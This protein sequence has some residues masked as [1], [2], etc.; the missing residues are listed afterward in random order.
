MS[1][2]PLAALKRD[3]N[4]D[5]HGFLQGMRPEIRFLAAEDREAIF[6]GALEVL[7]G[8]GMQVLHPEGLELLR[9]G[10]CQVDEQSMVRIPASLVSQALTTAPASIPVYDRLGEPAMDLGA[11]RSYFGTG[12]DLIYALDGQS[13]ER[14]VAGLND[15]ARAARV[16]DA[17]PN[18]DFVMSFAHP[19]DVS[20]H[21]AYLAS[22][23]TMAGNTTKPI[24]NTAENRS[25]LTEI[26][27]IGSLLRGSN[28]ALRERPYTIHYAEPIS[29]LKHPFESVDKL[30]L[31]AQAGMPCIYSPAPMA[32][33]TAP[34]SIAGHVVQGLA[35][36][37]CGLVMH[38]LKQP[39]APF[40]MGMGAAVLDMVSSEC[41][42]NAPE[43]Y[44]SYMAMIEMSHHLDLPSWG[45]AGTSDSQIPDGQATYEAGM[46]S[47]L[48]A[49]SGA[50][51]NHDVGYLD[52]G[53]TGS[54]EMIVICNE[55]IGQIRR[56]QK[57]IPVDPS[58]LALEVIAEIGPGGHYLMHEHTLD[59]VRGTQ[60]RP[61]LF[62]RVGRD[63][64]EA[65]GRLSLLDR[66]G[67]ELESIL[68]GHQ[69]EP[70]PREIQSRIQEAVD[71]YASTFSAASG[72]IESIRIQRK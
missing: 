52:F 11:T 9:K 65:K 7:F 61:K 57:G 67:Q 17:L 46:M 23:Q 49:L 16:C 43:Y 4:M 41:S 55:I 33:S 58:T 21:M 34:M 47:F 68:A 53:R 70:I 15:V 42:Y 3:V 37:L 63:A 6:Q 12:S 69:P 22:F 13:F 19:S 56:I 32:G 25:D 31:C 72:Q 51:L 66:A 60:W 1:A 54:L 14:S 35:E 45:Y 38:Q 28:Q 39:G 8:V 44:L 59:H 24:V 71:G 48:S 2:Q 36:S 26:C 50:N 62:S 30:L 10:G 20:P 40:L 29:P 64:W 5:M 27:R 18:I